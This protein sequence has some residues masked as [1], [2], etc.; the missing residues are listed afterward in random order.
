LTSFPF[1]SSSSSSSSSYYYYYYYYYYSSTTISKIPAPYIVSRI[2]IGSLIDLSFDNLEVWAE[3][4]SGSGGDE[5]VWRP[6]LL[7]SGGVDR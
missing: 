5:G 6:L 4:P 1:S 2:P 3:P 7:P